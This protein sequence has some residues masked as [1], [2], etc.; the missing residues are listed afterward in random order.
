MGVFRTNLPDA[1]SCEYNDENFIYYFS[2]YD[3]TIDG[4]IYYTNNQGSGFSASGVGFEESTPHELNYI[5]TEY[6]DLSLG[7]TTLSDFEQYNFNGQNGG[8]VFQNN[9]TIDLFLGIILFLV[10]FW[11]TFKLTKK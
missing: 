3:E 4:F 5:D 1:I 9:P 6:C 2:S 10:G 11:F 8:L 7:T